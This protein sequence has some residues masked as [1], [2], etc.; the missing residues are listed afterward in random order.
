MKALIAWGLITRILHRER[1]PPW[2]LIGGFGTHI[3]NGKEVAWTGLVRPM[4]TYML[5]LLIGYQGG[6]MAHDNQTRGGVL[7][8]IATMGV[9]LGVEGSP[10]FMA[11]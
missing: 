6:K 11:P 3:V 10:M 5:P 8:A 4:I 1:L 9:I 2:G 7:G